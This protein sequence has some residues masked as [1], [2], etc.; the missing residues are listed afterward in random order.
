MV[1]FQSNSVNICVIHGLLNDAESVE[2]HLLFEF[3]VVD[4]QT[5]C[6]SLL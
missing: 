5:Y 2:E 4:I 6:Q 3:L 1:S